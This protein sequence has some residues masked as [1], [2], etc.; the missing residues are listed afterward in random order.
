[1]GKDGHVP[2]ASYLVVLTDS[3]VGVAQSQNGKAVKVFQ[4]THGH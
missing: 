2:D 3:M 1:M 4:R